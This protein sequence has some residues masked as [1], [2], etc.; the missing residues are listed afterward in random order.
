VQVAWEEE[1][2]TQLAAL[3]AL[4]AASLMRLGEAQKSAAEVELRERAEARA[5][6]DAWRGLAASTLTRHR[7]ASATRTVAS[8][9][10]PAA[11]AHTAAVYRREVTAAVSRHTRRVARR[12][13]A[14]AGGGSSGGGG[15]GSAS[16]SPS[17]GARRGGGASLASPLAGPG[18]ANIVTCT[19]S[20]DGD[21]AVRSSLVRTPQVGVPSASSVV[22]IP[23]VVV[24]ELPT[25]ASRSK[26]PGGARAAAAAAAA[27]LA[28]A[29]AAAGEVA[30][31][32]EDDAASRGRDAGAALRQSREAMFYLE[33]MA[34]LSR[35]DAT[36]ALPP[37]G[38]RPPTT[39]RSPPAGRAAASAAGSASAAL[40][41][42]GGAP[43]PGA[44]PAGVVRTFA[45]RDSLGTDRFPEVGASVVARLAAAAAADGRTAVAG[46][47]TA[48]ARI[49]ELRAMVADPPPLPS[50]QPPPS[51]A[52]RQRSKWLAPPPAGGGGGG[53]AALEAQFEALLLAP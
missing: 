5:G 17:G 26:S 35:V 24:R 6:A 31:R 27:T 53:E 47:G 20:G 30:A 51:T 18:G 10:A 29:R 39:S 46:V 15:G 9:A 32:R 33:E 4:H 38:G 12:R 23:T 14:P 44:S 49:A 21:V 43:P 25:A 50:P 34:R 28:E 22:R 48:A 2:A 37:A 16:R 1:R 3:H 45:A 40:T 13:D 36:S 11:R 7:V 42:G 8:A 19:T 52:V 41:R